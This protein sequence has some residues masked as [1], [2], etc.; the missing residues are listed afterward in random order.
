MEK[1]TV[2]DTTCVSYCYVSIVG[3]IW[4][5]V[6]LGFAPRLENSASQLLTLSSHLALTKNWVKYKV[7]SA[8]SNIRN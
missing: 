4:I 2:L 1:V 6:S 7:N 5:L 8:K 3:K